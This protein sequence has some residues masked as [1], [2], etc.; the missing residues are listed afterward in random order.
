M[1]DRCNKLAVEISWQYLRRSTFYSRLWPVYHTEPLPLC[2]TRC[3]W[4]S[5][6][7]GSICDTWYLLKYDISFC[8]AE[9]MRYVARV[10]AGLAGSNGSLPP[11]L[12]LTSPAG[13]LPRTGISFGTVRSVLE[14]G[15]ALPFYHV[16]WTITII[17]F[18]HFLANNSTDLTN[19][20]GGPP[21]KPSGSL[22][23]PPIHR[24]TVT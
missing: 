9:E 23:W 1:D 6:S 10:T 24:V 8:A 14:Y 7:R 19:C 5:A 3:A 18:I 17:I 2:T 11:G 4:S 12:W 15:L 22:D 21:E 16:L 20:G 13:R